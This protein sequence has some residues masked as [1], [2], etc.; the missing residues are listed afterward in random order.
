MKYTRD[1]HYWLLAGPPLVIIGQ[2]VMI[3]L[4]NM[5]DGGRASEAAF[6]ASKVVSGCGRAFYQTAAQVSVQAAVTRQD[7]AVVTG[8]FQAANSI[9]GA[10]GTRY[11]PHP[12]LLSVPPFLVSCWSALANRSFSIAGTIWRNTLPS[13]LESFLP[14]EN[15]SDALSIFQNIKAAMAYPSGSPARVAINRSYSQSQM[16]LAIVSTAVS[17]PN[18]IIMFFMK[19]IKLDEEDEKDEK[20]TEQVIAEIEQQGNGR[21]GV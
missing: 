7:V 9:G 4:V 15:K 1:S 10:I 16:I 21:Q 13:K 20:G 2:G 11:G 14:D 6:I 3:Y 12:Y 8:V 5:P 18:L 19:K 17:A